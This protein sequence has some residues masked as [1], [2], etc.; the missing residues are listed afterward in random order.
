[1]TLNMALNGKLSGGVTRP[2][3]PHPQHPHPHHIV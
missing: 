3:H 1:M 2:Q